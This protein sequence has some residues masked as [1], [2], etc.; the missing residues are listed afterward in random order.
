MILFCLGVKI[1]MNPG[2]KHVELFQLL[3]SQGVGLRC[4]EFYK[5]WAYEYETAGDWKQADAIYRKGL[6]NMAQ[7]A[8][9]LKSAH[10]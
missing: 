7:P 6:D 1:E 10:Q 9:E 5:S 8:E 3:S 2:Q 4:A